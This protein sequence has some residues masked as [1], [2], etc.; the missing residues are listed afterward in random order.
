MLNTC[1]SRAHFQRA[2][3]PVVTYLQSTSSS[4][5][6]AKTQMKVHQIVLRYIMKIK[7]KADS[8]GNCRREHA[9]C[10]RVQADR[11]R[12]ESGFS[13]WRCTPLA[14]CLELYLLHKRLQRL[15]E[16][17]VRPTWLFCSH[18]RLSGARTAK[19]QH[20]LRTRFS[21]FF[22]LFFFFLF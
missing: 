12:H 9:A 10:W 18:P 13:L 22:F 15:R 19:F 1:F 21:F 8:P 7:R 5:H 17:D 16:L 3:V 4:R 14:A 11:A 2:R 20:A 6:L